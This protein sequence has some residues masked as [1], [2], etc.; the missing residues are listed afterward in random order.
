MPKN[1]KGNRFNNCAT[2][3]K[4]DYIETNDQKIDEPKADE[5][6]D[7]SNLEFNTDLCYNVK[8]SYDDKLNFNEILSKLSKDRATNFY[9][10]F[11]VG[12]AFINL[13]YRKVITRGQTYDMF[14]L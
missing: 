10:W 4:E 12:V 13:Y 3:I 11:Y 1:I 9:C 14:D 2:Y 6:K 5:V 8:A 7:I